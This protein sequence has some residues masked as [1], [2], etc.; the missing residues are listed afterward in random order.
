[1]S[2]LA[3]R[4]R[5][6]IGSRVE[7]VWLAVSPSRRRASVGSRGLTAPLVLV[8]ARARR[9]PSQWLPG[10]LGLA[11][12]T[13]FA[14]TVVAEAEIAG[15][16]AA[17]ATLA[18]AS[19]LGSTV[20]I[21]SQGPLA[22]GRGAQA[23]ALLDR[24]GLPAQT[25]VV[26]MSEVRLNGVVVRPVAIAPLTQWLPGP[27][28]ARLGRCTER[29]CPML[30]IGGSLHQTH[31]HA[32]GVHIHVIGSAPMR[33][34]APLGFEPASSPSPAIL[35]TG[36]PRGLDGI[37][38]LSGVY[39]TQNWLSM[40]PLRS[41][42]SWQL[43]ATEA[44]MQ[45]MQDKLQQSGGAFAFSGP[46][47]L[48][49]AAST[50][51]DAAPNR[52]LA[53]GGGAVAALSVFLILAAYGLRRERSG[54]V[55]RLLAAGART[56]QRVVFAVGESAVLCAVALIA[57]AAIGV[58]AAALLSG[59]A[60]VAA[61]GVLDHSL[62]T[63]TALAILGA[64]WLAATAVIS[65]V[66]LAPAAHLVD[67]LA[68][69]AAAALALALTRG[70][71]DGGALPALLA[72]LACIC[73]GVLVYRLAAI[74][75]RAGE[76]LA[77]RGPPLT[78]LALIS[79]ARTPTAPALAIAFIAVS[80]GLAGFALSY[81]STLLRG[82]ADQ[83]ANQVPL[84]E[85]VAPGASFQT[86]LHVAS[87]HRWDALA[88]GP[89]LPVRRT[90][91]NYL[92]GGSSV[93]VSAL[94]IP[95]AGLHLIHDW[96]QSDGSAPLATLA[97][98][99]QPPGVVRIPG[100]APAD[101]ARWLAV[102]IKAAGGGVLVSADLRDSAGAIRQLPLGTATPSARTVRAR[103]PRGGFEL[104]ALELDEPAGLE[105]TNGHQNGENPAAATQFSTPVSIGRL[106]WLGADGRRV[107]RATIASWRAVGAATNRGASSN[108]LHLR[109]SDSGTPGIVRPTQPSDLHPLPILA[110]DATAAAAGPGGQIA[111]T[112][113]GLAVN[114]RIV[115]VVRRFPTV[116][117]D[118]AGFVIADESRLAAALDASLPGQGRPDE[119]WIDSP[120]PAAIKAALQTP[121]FR[122]LTAS[123]R[124]DIEQR[125]RAQPIARG[126]LGI[127]LAAAAIGVVLALIGLLLA[128]LGALRDERAER[129]L[130]VH[131]LGPRA[132]AR[133][134]RTRIII[135]A[136]IGLSAGVAVAAGLTRLAV[137]AVSSAATLASPRPP[138]VTVAPWGELGLL[139]LAALAAFWAA[140]WIVTYAAI[141]RR[142]D[143]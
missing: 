55:E 84:D 10:L 93:T 48:L 29:S 21:T 140:S 61:G 3:A 67:M 24:L 91:A 62:L 81:R 127:L 52:L 118:A 85:L 136:V 60:G 57:G 117:A 125:L 2:S 49:D 28:A 17:R 112:I 5:L 133:E 25:R 8:A 34:A 124:A 137:A 92:S 95:A 87:L 119:L 122:S 88:G 31:L 35:A 116:A 44:R 135:A 45:R 100:P 77:R 13:A 141:G 83:A 69:A 14:C 58:L 75:L 74:A 70:T 86:P 103:L 30:L 111:L 131:G 56:G 42:Q 121:R 9:R 120:R 16:R 107:G 123:F 89:V 36:D 54:D 53:A 47:N 51:A 12:A 102:S 76:R 40:L 139:A 98:R 129:E 71:A 18:T 130:V 114:A 142:R 72:P 41:L 101:S 128:L 68:V 27:L 32:F 134:L 132:L 1:M 11:L 50:Q 115:G 64:A 138:L 66:L 80:T 20:R 105:A 104:E 97:Q 96:R 59:G 82:T 79:L 106:E 22:A 7:Q 26:L 143:P 63:P 126:V 33:A 39:R 23:R 65:V 73:A 90:D 37:P 78:R 4:L 43:A 15:D 110:D 94:G 46:F 108:V 99:L 38:G 19:S 113:D 109:F 6:A